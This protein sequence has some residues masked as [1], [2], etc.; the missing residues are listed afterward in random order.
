MRISEQN[1]VRLG[2]FAGKKDVAMKQK[3]GGAFV[4]SKLG[5]FAG[6]MEKIATDS[7]SVM[8]KTITG[9][10]DIE[11]FVPATPPAKMK[12]KCKKC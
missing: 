6:K 2:N 5:N 3:Y 1:S 4:F 12:K 11:D 10:N 9:K 8:L 7:T